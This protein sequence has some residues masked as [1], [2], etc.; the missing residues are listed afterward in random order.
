MLIIS[1]LG[2]GI[3]TL[4]HFF[5]QI[6]IIMGLVILLVV[7]GMFMFASDLLVFSLK[8]FDNSKSLNEL[9]KNC[10]GKKWR[11]FFDILFFIYLFLT[12]ISIVLTVSKTFY[13]NFGRPI[14]EK[15]FHYKFAG[16]EDFKSHFKD[17][18][19]FFSYLVGVVFYFLVIQRD[20]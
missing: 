7:C 2:T 1:A 6:G 3:L 18:N 11:I 15:W 9:V 4:H 16:D 10:L 8:K 17:F 19:Q 14:M 5:N 12:S 13:L 20:I